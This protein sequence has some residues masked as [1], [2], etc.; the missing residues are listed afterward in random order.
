MAAIDL[1]VREQRLMPVGPADRHL[2]SRCTGSESEVSGW[3]A[4]RMH[5]GG[6]GANPL[7]EFTPFRS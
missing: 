4:Y 6:P 3:L 7:N 1:E 2:Y 5:P